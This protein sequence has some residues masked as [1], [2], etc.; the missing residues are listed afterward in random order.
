MINL[1]ILIKLR[2]DALIAAAHPDVSAEAYQA[3]VECANGCRKLEMVLRGNDLPVQARFE[4]DLEKLYRE[5]SIPSEAYPTDVLRVATKLGED[6]SKLPDDDFVDLVDELA[7]VDELLPEI[8]KIWSDLRLSL[9]E[10]RRMEVNKLG[11][12]ITEALSTGDYDLALSYI[13]QIRIIAGTE[14]DTPLPQR[15]QLAK[16][17]D[18]LENILKSLKAVDEATE[19]LDN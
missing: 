3:Y 7:S 19:N 5:S 6:I 12:T 11:L 16:G 4:E 17:I 18:A 1:E 9:P 8:S 15:M 14:G 10:G 2:C 13:Q